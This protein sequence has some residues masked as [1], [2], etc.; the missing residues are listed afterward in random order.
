MDRLNV[1]KAVLWLWV[2]WHLVF[3]LL[4]TFAPEAGA[5]AVGWTA[6]GG[7]DAELITMSTQYGMVMVLLAG[8]FMITALDPLRYLGMIWVAVAEQILGMA[9]AG[10]IYVQFGQLTIAQMLLQA[11]INTIVIIVLVLLWMGLRDARRQPGQ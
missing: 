6:T 4:A 7:W 2:L 8:V 11:G 9:Y 3:G 1:L 5:N 10:Y